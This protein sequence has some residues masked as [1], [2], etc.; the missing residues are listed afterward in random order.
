MSMESAARGSARSAAAAPRGRSR[1][2]HELI[3]GPLVAS[4]QDGHGGLGTWVRVTRVIQGC[5]AQG[6]TTLAMTGM[7]GD[8]ACWVRAGLTRRDESRSSPAATKHE[9]GP[10]NWS[11]RREM[12]PTTAAARTAAGRG[13]PRGDVLIAPRVTWSMCSWVTRDRSAPAMIFRRAGGENEPG[14][15][16]RTRPVFSR[17][18]HRVLVLGQLHVYPS[19]QPRRRRRRRGL[20]PGDDPGHPRCCAGG[21]DSQEP[22]N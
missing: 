20:S 7:S 3:Q 4:Q 11:W 21:P 6:K 8:H 10:V 16:D 18:T 9:R 5:V 1:R 2:P 13:R 15:D 17:T 12:E 19:R 22:R 14:D